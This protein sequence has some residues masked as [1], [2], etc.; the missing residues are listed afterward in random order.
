LIILVH[1]FL[2]QNPLFPNKGLLVREIAFQ[3]CPFQQIQ[4]PCV[5]V[6][7]G[8]HSSGEGESDMDEVPHEVLKKSSI[9][10]AMITMLFTMLFTM[11]STVLFHA[12]TPIL[13]GLQGSLGGN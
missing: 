5:Q 3:H 4:V 6:S 7:V 12:S 2:G 13:C 11:L 8:G 10:C 9:P 1:H